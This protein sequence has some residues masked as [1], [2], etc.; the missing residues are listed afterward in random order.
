MQTV[1]SAILKPSSYPN[2]IK[3]HELDVTKGCNVKCIYCGLAYSKKEVQ[4]VVVDIE[5][6]IQQTPDVKGIYLSPNT[7]AFSKI[8]ADTTHKILESLLPKGIKFL[9]FTKNVIPDETINLLAKYPEQITIKISL[10]RIDQEL[11][12]YIEPGS[13]SATNRLKTMKALVDAGIEK[14]QV[15]LMPL[16][17]G[18]DDDKEKIIDLIDEIRKTGVKLVKAAFVVI[19]NSEKPKDIEMITKMLHHPELKKSWE[20][21]TETMKVQIGEGQIF[22][23]EK[24]L[25]FYQML[26]KICADRDMNFS[27]CTVLDSAL[28]HVTV[29]DFKI[30]KSL[31][32]LPDQFKNEIRVQIPA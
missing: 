26:S 7:D 20:L 17:P 2:C 24:R 28:N 8:C 15:V 29:D 12:K 30:C 13:A 31:Q 1:E 6:L 3:Y 21:M 11:I 19:R 16:Y 18:V 32:F 23:F 22:P 5:E 4:R 10:A 9:L 25:A 27:A 14:V